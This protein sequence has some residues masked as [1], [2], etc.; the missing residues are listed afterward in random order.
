MGVSDLVLDLA[1]HLLEFG[2][3]ESVYRP[4]N[5]NPFHLDNYIALVDWTG[6]AVRDDKLGYIP[7]DLAPVI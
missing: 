1:T 7:Q 6:R 5:T 4:D 3:D 2:G